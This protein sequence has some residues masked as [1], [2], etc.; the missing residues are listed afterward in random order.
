[1]QNTSPDPEHAR[2]FLELLAAMGRRNSLRDPFAL[3][4]SRT[5]L[6][7]AQLQA[8]MWLHRDG[9]LV[10]GQVAQR[11][12]VNQ[13]TVTGIVDRLEK[14]GFVN[15]ER[16][17]EDRRVVRVAISARGTKLAEQLE[18]SITQNVSRFLQMLEARDRRDLFRIVENLVAKMDQQYLAVP[19]TASSSD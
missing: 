9:P 1:M 11:I 16:N 2:Q 3:R 12:S 19:V 17:A 18:R 15:R 7:P 5:E 14:Q 6:G 10:M 8:L 4:V 13:K